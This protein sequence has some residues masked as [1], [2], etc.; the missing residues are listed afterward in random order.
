V[1]EREM[2]HETRLASSAETPAPGWERNAADRSWTKV[3][4][5][6]KGWVLRRLAGVS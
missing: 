6:H 5:S 2:G 4:G 1:R 3:G